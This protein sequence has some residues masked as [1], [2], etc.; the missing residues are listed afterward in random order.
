MVCSIENEV[1]PPTSVASD[2]DMPR[3]VGAREVEQAAAEEQVGGRAERRRP[4]PVS[5][6]RAQSASSS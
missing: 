6:M 2:S 1:P 3:R 4:R 5:A